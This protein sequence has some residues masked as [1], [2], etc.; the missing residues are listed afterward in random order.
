MSP[1]ALIAL[2][3]ASAQPALPRALVNPGFEAGAPDTAH[4]APL[5][6]WSLHP[7]RGYRA[8]VMANT[9]YGA[10]RAPAGRQRLFLGY[11]ARNGPDRG[12]WVGVSQTVD[13]RRW[14]GRRI[15][16]SVA[17]NPAHFAA[18]RAW[19]TVQSGSIIARQGFDQVEQWRRYA[20]ELEIP[21][22]ATSLTIGIG[23]NGDVNVDD[24]RIEAVRR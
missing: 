24:V 7:A 11:F 8:V 22:D 5:H 13:A 2:F 1:A 9:D 23:T 20:V 17:A 21:R 4:Q 14:R 16:V 6:G 3:L 18:H 15:R 12:S 19:L 10:M